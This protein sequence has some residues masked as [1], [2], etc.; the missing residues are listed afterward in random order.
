MN[1]QRKAIYKKRKNALFGDRLDIDIDN[2]FFELCETTVQ[3]HGGSNFHDFEL[4]LLRIIGIESPISADEF[5]KISN[6]YDEVF[7]LIIFQDELHSVFI[8]IRRLVD[9]VSIYNF[10]LFNK[11]K[12]FLLNIV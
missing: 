7:A 8:L 10:Q 9:F 3:Q 6:T 1:A 11:L 4:E 2:M 12:N 5:D